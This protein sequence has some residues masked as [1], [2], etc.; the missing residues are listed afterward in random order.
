MK[1]MITQAREA[2]HRL[3][4]QVS[5]IEI[6]SLEQN[7]AEAADAADLLA[8]IKTAKTAHT[9]VCEVL[10]NGQPRHV[11][12]A[13]LQL[14]EHVAYQKKAIP[15][16]MAPYL[17]PAARAMCRD[18]QV[19]F[20][21]LQGNAW[22]AFDGVFIERQVTD[23]PVT[24]QRALKSLFKPK[25]AQLLRAML[26]EPEKAWRVTELAEATGVS[27]GHVSN[28]RTALL[29]REWARTMSSGLYLSAPD[30][31]LDA[32]SSSYE[33]PLGERK[34]F[35]SPLHGAL[36]EDA[37][38]RAFNQDLKGHGCF[39]SF[40][41][42]NWIAPYARVGTLHFYADHQ[43]LEVLKEALQL[44]PVTKGDNIVITLPKDKALLFDTVE[45]SPGVLCTD[46]IQTYLDLSIAGE[47]GQEAAHYL[48]QEKFRW[49]Q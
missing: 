47:P 15:V 30:E 24:E 3:L 48:R 10:P 38:R 40:S 41:A 45:P 46:P 49:P 5:I 31:L 8:H 33:T 42:S 44:T 32:W 21:D 28:V 34:H 13:L 18:K 35:Y 27:L 17:S 1:E 4:S 36:L 43:G 29:D 25:S 37:A 20:L 23:K 2:L 7:V 16:L 9:L 14:H 39:S 19:G 6:E 22:I 12:T 11:R 26:R